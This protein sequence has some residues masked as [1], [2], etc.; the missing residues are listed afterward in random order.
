MIVS[1]EIIQADVAWKE[2][3][4]DSY[5]GPVV[6]NCGKCPLLPSKDYF[7]ELCE[8]ILAQQISGK[9]AL[10]FS[11]RLNDVLE[12][13]IDP[14]T[15][16]SLSVEE[17]RRLGISVR[18]AESLLDLAKHCLEGQILL[19]KI[20]EMPEMEIRER[21][22]KVKGIGPWTVTMFLIFA[23]NRSRVIPSHDFGIRKAIQKLYGLAEMPKIAEVPQYFLSWAPHESVASWYLWRSLENGGRA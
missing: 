22:T 2:L 19:E 3:Q 23:L 16:S 10:I 7:R 1:A 18:K 15:V 21:L 11:K 9:V 12:G 6:L 13:I 17:M 5:L 20:R 14:L 4:E 8:S